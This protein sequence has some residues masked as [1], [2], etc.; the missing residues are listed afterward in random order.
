MNFE[1]TP[2]S[3]NPGGSQMPIPFGGSQQSHNY[4]QQY[5]PQQYGNRYA[6]EPQAKSGRGIFG[7]ILLLMGVTIGFFVGFYYNKLRSRV[8]GLVGKPKPQ[9]FPIVPI[10]DVAEKTIEQQHKEFRDNSGLDAFSLK[11]PEK[12]PIGFEIDQNNEEQ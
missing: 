2:I 10:A 7:L 4:Q 12:K 3:N 6:P 8:S 9:P 1:K 5:A 11:I